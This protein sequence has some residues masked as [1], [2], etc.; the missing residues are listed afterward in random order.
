MKKRGGNTMKK[1]TKEE[2]VNWAK[3]QRRRYQAGLLQ[4]WQV[5][6]LKKEGFTFGRPKKGVS[7]G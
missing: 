3:E 6:A 4:P 5:E 7:R 2:I 1:I